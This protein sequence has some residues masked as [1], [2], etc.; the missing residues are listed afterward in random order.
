[1]VLDF[2]GNADVHEGPRA[3]WIACS[4]AKAVMR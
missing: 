3:G 4:I 1:V 2:L